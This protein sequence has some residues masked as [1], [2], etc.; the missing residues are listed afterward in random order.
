MPSRLVR[1]AREGEGDGLPEEITHEFMQ[2][3][4]GGLQMAMATAIQTLPQDPTS[5]GVAPDQM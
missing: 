4:F 5:A 1:P 2:R 3:L